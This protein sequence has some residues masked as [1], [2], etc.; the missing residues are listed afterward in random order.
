MEKREVQKAFSR[1]VWLWFKKN[2]RELPW[3]DLW[4]LEAD[5]RAYR[6][7]VSEVMLQQTQVPRVISAF[8]IFL[9]KFPTLAAL[10]SAS[11]R[12][13]LIAWKG[14]GYNSRALRLR[15]AAKIILTKF[16]A[17][18]PRDLDTL[19]TIPG[20]GPYTAA[21]IL[22]FAFDIPTPCI[23]TNILRILHRFFIAPEKS[24]GTWKSGI[25]KIS[26]QS[27]TTLDIALDL[28][29]APKKPAAEWHA[30]L[31]DFGSLV[32]TKRTPL[33]GKCPLQTL[34]KSAGKVPVQIKR[35]TAEIQREPGFF[36]NKTF[37]PRR[38][39]RGRTV[40]LLRCASS[41]MTARMI[42]SKLDPKDRA[43]WLEEVLMKLLL[44]GMIQRVGD[45][46]ALAD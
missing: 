36:I 9:Q 40:E 34:C 13:I 14:M 6:I 30:A 44:D 12:E 11:N 5:N 3:R 28:P 39:L 29:I 15:D 1:K 19:Q 22:N 16:N 25:S 35:T 23:D 37:V 4:N 46:Y 33:C 27:T 2:R 42:A 31:M 38:I 17:G 26:L 32:C 41:P 8:K 21:A 20:I 43:P 10:A 7:L 24:D 18:F 45:R